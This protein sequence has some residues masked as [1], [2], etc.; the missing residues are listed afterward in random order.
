MTALKIALL[1][2]A[3]AAG[4]VGAGI[5]TSTP[6]CWSQS[7]NRPLECFTS[8]S[9]S[10]STSTD[11][12]DTGTTSTPTTT[13]GSTTT[14]TTSTPTYFGTDPSNNC[15]RTSCTSSLPRTD[16]TCTSEVVP[17]SSEPR[18][19][20]YTANHSVPADPT[21]VPWNEGANSLY[22]Q[23]F[24]ANRNQVTGNFTGTTTEIIQW[25][26]CKW[27]I[28]EDTLRA[29][30]AQESDWHQSAVG[31]NCGVVGEASYG[32]MQI[33]NKYCSGTL[34]HGGYP[35]TQNY[36][37]LNVDYYGSRF[38]S[39][40]DGDYYDGGTWLYGGQTV[41]QIAAAKGWDYVF[42]GCI[43]SWFS[44]DWY[45]PGAVSYIASV[46][47]HLATLPITTATTIATTT[48]RT[49]TASATATPSPSPGSALSRSVG[50]VYYVSTAGSDADPGTL[51][52]PW[53]TVQ[54]ALNT[55]Q[56]G[57]TALVRAGAYSADLVMHRAGTATAPITV[58]NYPG[59]RPVLQPTASSTT[60]PVRITKG[61]A[62]FHLQ[63]FVIKNATSR[64]AF[65]IRTRSRP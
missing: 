35:D 20:N 48:T 30:A 40:Y 28:D 64:C 4:L 37:A 26:A 54:K 9:T 65:T 62:W 49:A 39:C 21:R 55:L 7:P 58:K 50:S 59:E 8:T 14:G 33:K 63:G 60:C 43:G 46:R 25:A 42:W 27:G 61:A 56:P 1:L 57:E 44:G 31:D 41:G 15:T 34:A 22:W 29:V 5:A 45:D 16:A 3:F 52:A 17:N 53:R 13:D 38:R 32:I 47:A 19:D 6:P 51:S 36:T 2:A 11:T 18:P 12:T 23:S 24:V 10:T